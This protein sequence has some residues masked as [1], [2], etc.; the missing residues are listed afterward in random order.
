MEVV[1]LLLAIAEDL[2]DSRGLQEPVGEV[3]DRATTAALTDN[4]SEAE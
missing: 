3:P 2:Q 1:L 4:R